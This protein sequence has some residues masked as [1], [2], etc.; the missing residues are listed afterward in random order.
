VLAKKLIKG[1]GL[2]KVTT[3][4]KAWRCTLVIPALGKQKRK[5]FKFK[6]SLSYIHNKTLSQNKRRTVIE[7]SNKINRSHAC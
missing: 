5:D 6:A 3:V 4:S 7:Y 2:A 1:A